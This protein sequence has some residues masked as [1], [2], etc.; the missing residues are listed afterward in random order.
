[1]ETR[2]HTDLLVVHCSAT[3]PSQDIGVNEIRV[4]HLKR[5]F[6]DIGYHYIIRRSG[7]VCAG[8]AEN[9]IGAHVQG[10]NW[11]SIGI[12][13]VGGVNARNKP[14]NNFTPEQFVALAGLL[15]SLRVKY[16]RTRI[17]GHRDL[18]PDLDGDGIVEPQEWVKYC[19]CFE[20][21]AWLASVGIPQNGLPAMSPP[22]S[23]D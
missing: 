15:A 1:M 6:D 9:S 19:P 20:V 23:K 14:E 8:R 10:H 13:M 5:K 18:S 22:P 12:C 21:A 2:I 11:N 16:P 3:P 4:M 17:V 7:M